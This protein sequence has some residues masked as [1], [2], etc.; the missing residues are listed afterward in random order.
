MKIRN[1]SVI[2][3]KDRTLDLDVT[4]QQLFEWKKGTLIQNAFPNLSTFQREFLVTGSTEEEW[5][6]LFPNE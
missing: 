2:T 4:I 1:I 6:D 3:G 5:E